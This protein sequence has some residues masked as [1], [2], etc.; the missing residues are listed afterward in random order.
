MHTL[1]RGLKYRHVIDPEAS[2]SLRVT[3]VTLIWQRRAPH[4]SYGI[5]RD[6][7]HNLTQYHPAPPPYFIITSSTQI[8][9]NAEIA[10]SRCTSITTFLC[11]RGMQI[12]VKCTYLQVLYTFTQHET[13]HE[14][15]SQPPPTGYILCS[16]RRAADKSAYALLLQIIYSWIII[17][18]HTT[19][20]LTPLLPLFTTNCTSLHVYIQTL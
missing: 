15:S 2:D 1:L 9:S 6:N 13:A 12:S 20:I 11:E 19:K 16:Q 7:S 14:Q 10:G 8:V 18:K 17:H 5:S 4:D 3:W